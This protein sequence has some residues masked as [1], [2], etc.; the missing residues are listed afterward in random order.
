V[1]IPQPARRS[2]QSLTRREKEA[3]VWL[4][5]GKTSW[6]ISVLFDISEGA[7]NKLIARSVEKLGAVNR[8]QAVVNAIRLGEIEI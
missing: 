4:A 7:V 8:T 6:E 1:K 5:V 2:T 3:M